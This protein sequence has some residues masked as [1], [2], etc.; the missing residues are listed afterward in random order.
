MEK[1]IEF[2]QQMGVTP[3][4][5]AYGEEALKKLERQIDLAIQRNFCRFSV[6]HG[7]GNGILQGAVCEYLKS[8][9]EIESFRFA[10]PED[11]GTGKTYVVISG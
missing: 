8:R 10:L 11:G 2:Y 3:S 6:I 9:P 4:V 5:Y 7:K 1:L